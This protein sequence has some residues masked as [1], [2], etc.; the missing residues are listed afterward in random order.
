MTRVVSMYMHK[1]PITLEENSPVEEALEVIE[2]YQISH[3]LVTSKGKLT[4]VVSKNDLLAKALDLL[5]HS[6]GTIYNLLELRTRTIDYIMG[7][8]IIT[9]KP[10]D[11][12]A[13]GVEL[14]LHNKFHCLP[15]VD[16]DG[17]P[18]GIITA[19]DLLKGY[20]QEEG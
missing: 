20:Y 18:I 9:L 2:K 19:F 16:D 14:L 6:S 17:R 7:E 11:T 8:N 5:E 13:H 1:N 3:I 4:G 10:T 15:V 12:M